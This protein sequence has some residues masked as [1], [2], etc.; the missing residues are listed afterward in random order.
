MAL[1]K[2][3]QAGGGCARA[4]D[5]DGYSLLSPPLSQAVVKTVDMSDEME[6]DAI[7]IATFALNEHQIE[8]HMANHIKR[9]FDKKYR[10]CSSRAGAFLS[11]SLWRVLQ[12]GT[13]LTR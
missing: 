1:Q 3:R 12:R 7:E 2:V 5:G 6:K 9:E 4:R 8:S 10:C 11:L 13:I